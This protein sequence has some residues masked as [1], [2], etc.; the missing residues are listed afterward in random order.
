[1]SAV[2]DLQTYLFDLRGYVNIEG[3]LSAV[4]PFRASIRDSGT[5]M[6]T[7]TA[8]MAGTA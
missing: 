3:A 1:M 2:T 4:Q 5:G 6:Y 8:T 7:A